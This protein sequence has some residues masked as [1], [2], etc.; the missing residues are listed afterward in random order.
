MSKAI[1]GIAIGVGVIA[2]AVAT[3]GISIAPTVAGSSIF[4]VT[5]AAVV[6]GLS[7]TA[8]GG[9]ALAAGASLALSGVQQLT[10]RPPKV[11]LTTLGRLNASSDPSTDRKAA[12][13]R[14]ALPAD[15]RW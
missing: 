1:T 10:A 9:L 8:L 15:I 11:S 7:T 2:L 12:F 4:G 3:G 13:G 14:T 5:T 6:G